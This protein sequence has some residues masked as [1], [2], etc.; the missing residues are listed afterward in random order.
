MDSLIEPTDT[1]TADKFPPLT[2]EEGEIVEDV[3]ANERDWYGAMQLAMREACR[4]NN[5]VLP[6][7]VQDFITQVGTWMALAKNGATDS[8]R[9]QKVEDLLK[10]N[11]QDLQTANATI[12][13]YK[14]DL[15]ASSET[16]EA[17]QKK[18]ARTEDVLREANL[19]C[20]SAEKNR[21]SFID[22]INM[23]QS[24][25]VKVRDKVVQSTATLQKNVA[26]LVSDIFEEHNRRFN[27][28]QHLQQLQQQQEP[29]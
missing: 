8:V 28:G 9:L 20:T 27:Q 11:Q 14:N 21:R 29:S 2:V 3:L 6:E 18:L 5:T 25:L 15:Q 23:S 26:A 1:Q 24:A 17:L 7:T 13:K 10:T 19:R 22:S 4:R 12:H 16:V